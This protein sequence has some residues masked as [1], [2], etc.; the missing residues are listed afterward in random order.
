MVWWRFTNNTFRVKYSDTGYFKNIYKETHSQKEAEWQPD[1]GRQEEKA[2]EAKKQ[3]WMNRHACLPGVSKHHRVSET[4][5]KS[6]ESQVHKPY[7]IE[8]LQ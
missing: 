4:L 6:P 7:R 1:Q 3:E 2:C 8:P 5:S